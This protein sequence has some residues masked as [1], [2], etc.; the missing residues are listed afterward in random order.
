[1][2]YFIA[3]PDEDKFARDQMGNQR[4]DVPT[5]MRIR[6]SADVMIW[7]MDINERD[8]MHTQSLRANDDM[9]VAMSERYFITGHWSCLNA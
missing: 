9:V 6:I 8:V 3:F 7:E 4:N 5:G 2:E 1:M